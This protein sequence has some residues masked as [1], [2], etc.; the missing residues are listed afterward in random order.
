M[1][2][3]EKVKEFLKNNKIIFN[4]NGIAKINYSTFNSENKL[5][6]KSKIKIWPTLT[7]VGAHSNLKLINK[8]KE[9]SII[10]GIEMLEIQG[11]KILPS[12][13]NIS[14][15]TL[16]FLAGNSISIYALKEHFK[17]VK[18]KSIGVAFGGI[19]AIGEFF[20]RNKIIDYIEIEKKVVNAH[21]KIYKTNYVVKDFLK[22]NKMKGELLHFSPPCKN[23]SNQGKKTRIDEFSQ[24]II[25]VIKNSNP[26][27]VSI[28]NVLG[29]KSV[30]VKIK[31]EIEDFYNT[32]IKVIVPKNQSRKRIFLLGI[33]K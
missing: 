11:F 15:A 4:N 8:N 7:S 16:K 28:E 3:I 1:S 30:M 12:M 21:N 31:K 22:I 29:Y 13:K 14:N 24:N 2:S 25:N 6:D 10:T 17:N 18:P 20:G 19:D 27:I 26:K 23:F 9:I 33:K 32:S 5:I